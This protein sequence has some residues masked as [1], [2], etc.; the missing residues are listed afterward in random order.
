MV[1]PLHAIVLE[2]KEFGEAD[3]MVSIFSLEHGRERVIAKG[4]RRPLSTM[5]AA[6]ELFTLSALL[7][8]DSKSIPQ[9]T[10]AKT[11]DNFNGLKGVLPRVLT[12]HHIAEIIIKTTAEKDPNPTVFHL[13]QQTFLH[14]STTTR[15]RLTLE[16]F[17]L[18]YLNASGL[19]PELNH[20]VGCNDDIYQGNNWFSAQAEG[21]ECDNCRTPDA[22][23][24]SVNIIK[25]LRL[26]GK[27]DYETV[28]RISLDKKDQADIR[29]FT[30][31]LI[32]IHTQYKLNSTKF[33]ED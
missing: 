22:S 17:R 21:L 3:R 10:E 27:S 25:L 1:E 2:R 19:T 23:K 28:S 9:V 30:Q 20:C 7:V 18:K 12:A 29:E 16:A 6:L 8:T 24:V 5:K 4:I 32:E 26:F 11:V 33:L 13:L 14:L 31:K 15:P